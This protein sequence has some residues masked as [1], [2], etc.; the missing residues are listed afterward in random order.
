MSEDRFFAHAFHRSMLVAAAASLVGMAS[1]QLPLPLYEPFNY[2]ASTNLTTHD[3]WTITGANTLSPVQVIAN[4]LAY[5]GLP[6]PVGNKVAVLNGTSFE[7][8][9][10]DVGP[11]SGEN[12]SVFVSFLVNVVNPGN[13]TGEYFLHVCSAGQTSTDFHSRA[14]IRQSS[15]TTGAFNFGIRQ[16]NN[17]VIQFETADRAAATTFFVV[18]SYDFV[19]GTTNDTSRMWVNPAL[20]QT[21]PPAPDLTASAVGSTDTD[22]TAVGRLNLRQP[23]ADTA[24]SIE[25]DEI[26][27]DTTWANV[28][29]AG[30][31][32]QDWSVY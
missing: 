18:V 31:A 28:T 6:T 21:T 17:D 15:V 23:S 12:T 16:H 5:A 29:P 26:R 13:T 4:S 20:G 24:L 1:A 8:P 14:F 32:V 11:A 3:G 10:V 25:V 22:L 7:D 27:M 2:D 9:G 19:A 30:S